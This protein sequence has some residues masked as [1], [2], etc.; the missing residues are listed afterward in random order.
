MNKI[1]FINTRREEIK[2]EETSLRM[3]Q[4]HAFV[5]GLLVSFS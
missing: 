5:I 2:F 1:R 3:L 4:D